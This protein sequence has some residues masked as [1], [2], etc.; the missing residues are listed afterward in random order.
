MKLT[1]FGVVSF[2]CVLKQDKAE[3]FGYKVLE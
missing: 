1:S 2:L 3:S